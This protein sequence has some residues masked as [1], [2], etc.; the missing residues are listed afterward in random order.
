MDCLKLERNGPVARVLLSRPDVRNAFDAE[1]IGR[2]RET[3]ESLSKDASVRVVVLAGEGKT[4]CG[5]ADVNWMKAS[6][7][8]SAEENRE[9]ARRMA[10]MYRTID[11]CPKLVVG[12]VQGAAM[13]GGTGL[14]AC[15]DVAIAAPDA[16]FAFSEVKLGIVP[17]VISNFVLPKI[18]FSNAR[19]YF[20]TGEIFRAPAAKEMGLVQVVTEDLAKAFEELRPSLLAPGPNAVAEAKALLRTVARLNRDDAIAHC[21]STIARVRTSAEG[22]EGLR[23]F[24]EKRKP[25]WLASE[26]S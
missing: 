11:E 2:L 5:G 4:F 24:L 22:Q 23:A 7:A 9:D 18:G 17:A 6:L 10:G 25:S 13:G 3:F 8:L 16:Q 12:L 20:L 1:L 19:R 21:V 14:V 26:K 15:C